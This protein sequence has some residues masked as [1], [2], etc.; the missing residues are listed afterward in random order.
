MAGRGCPVGRAFSSVPEGSPANTDMYANGTYLHINPFV[1]AMFFKFSFKIIPL[2]VPK[3]ECHSLRGG[4]KLWWRVSVPSLGISSQVFVYKPIDLRLFWTW[5]Y[6]EGAG[7][8]HGP[9]LNLRKKT[10]F[11]VRTNKNYE[12][13]TLQNWKKKINY[14]SKGMLFINNI[15]FWTGCVQ[16]TNS[17]F[18]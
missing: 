1:G 4:S 8:G 6:A 2:R 12:Y 16:A 18:F 15:D 7:E 17:P 3:E 14:V 11:I 13:K 10:F 9:P 5:V